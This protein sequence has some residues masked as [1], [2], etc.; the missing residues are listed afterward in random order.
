MDESCGMANLSSFTPFSG[1]WMAELS[2]EFCVDTIS[3][4]L[5]EGPVMRPCVGGAVEDMR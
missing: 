2:V 1:G 4:G 5:T 3:E